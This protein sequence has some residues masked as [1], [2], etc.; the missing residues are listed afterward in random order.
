MR[1]AICEDERHYREKLAKHIKHC[2]NVDIP[3]DVYDTGDALLQAYNNGTRYDIL[4]LDIQMP[5]ISG[6]DAAF[7]IKKMDRGALFV[8]ITSL[9]G[10]IRDAFGVRA[11]DYI[12]KTVDMDGL[13]L[14]VVLD[15]CMQEYAEANKKITIQTDIGVLD[16]NVRDIVCIKGE[17]RKL[18]LYMVT[19]DTIQTSSVQLKEAI[20]I[21]EPFDFVRCHRNYLI[22]LWAIHDIKEQV[23]YTEADIEV[24]VSRRMIMDVK[25][26]QNRLNFKVEGYW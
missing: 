15:R 6:M 16:I 21:F 20:R 1:I 4:F 26:E 19:G 7:E 17:R 23:I 25:H 2:L 11:I 14:P 3:L 18:Q 9:P 13:Q 24:P 10:H 8:F 22:N 5:G 12:P